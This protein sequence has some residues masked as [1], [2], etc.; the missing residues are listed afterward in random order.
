M[1]MK[2][3]FSS[4][5]VLALSLVFQELAISEELRLLPGEALPILEN[6]Q[7]KASISLGKK[8][9]VYNYTYTISNPKS[10]TGEIWS[11]DI[12]ITKPPR[13]QEISK[14]GIINGPRFARHSS[15]LV[16]STIGIPLIPVGLFSPPDWTS[17]LSM[18]GTA[19]WGS[20][21]AP[22]RIHPGQSLSGFKM[23]SRGLPGIR[24][25]KI[26]PKFKQT[27]VLDATRED[28]E[29]ITAIEK[30]ILIT[31]KTIGPTVPPATFIPLD[32]LAYL[33]DLKHQ[34]QALGWIGGPK[35]VEE[36]DKKLDQA[37]EKLL[38]GNTESAQGKL[39]SFIEKVEAHFKETEEHEIEKIKEEKGKE[40]EDKKFVTSEGYG[41]LVFNAQYLRDQLGPS[42]G[43][44]DEEG[45][46]ESN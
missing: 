2:G 45:E 18:D 26:E 15:E 34:A 4:I 33:I 5:T 36:L 10:N 32:F 16:L 21:D 22:F 13:S 11:V 12:D 1:K 37:K 41:L 20:S 25:I 44:E 3:F 43:H 40:L 6:V 8:L 42:K 14:E 35:L 17:G 46:K 38:A 7:V 31:L 9:S 24:S 29:R 39:K 27:P 28:V 30:A 23:V 19:G